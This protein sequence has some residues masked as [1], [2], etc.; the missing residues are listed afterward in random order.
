MTTVKPITD[1]PQL[2]AYIDEHWRAGHV[3]ARDEAMFR[4]TYM[5]PW[6]DSRAFPGGI[7]ALGLFDGKKLLGFL[8]AISA[9]YPRPMSLWLALWHVHPSLKGQGLGGKLLEK[10]QQIAEWN[11]GWIGTFGAGPEALPVYLKKGYAVR[12]AR[13]WV[14]EPAADCGV[15]SD[16]SSDQH[17]SDDL[18]PASQYADGVE[19]LSGD[20]WL[21]YRYNEH[22]AFAYEGSNGT[23]TRTESNEWGVVTHVCRFGER[24]RAEIERAHRK[25]RA[26][27]GRTGQYLMDCWSFDCPGAGWSLAPQDSP[28]VF[29]PVQARGNI[30]YAVGLPFIPSMIGKGDCDQDRPNVA[31]Q[32]RG[33]R[34][35]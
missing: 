10:M 17:A 4:F 7:S 30:T 27:A 18:S 31:E 29:H 35:A 3:L 1:R 28:S 25:G 15:M 16:G 24:W 12:A 11:K 19:T 32:L 20:D 26:L 14:F 22:P 34:A 8:G 6:V 5:T 9:N 21:R 23:Y 13:R 33:S 2:Q